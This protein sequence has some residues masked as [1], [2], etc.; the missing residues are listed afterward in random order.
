LDQCPPCQHAEE[1]LLEVNAFII[2]KNTERKEKM[3]LDLS[4]EIAWGM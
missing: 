3:H 2:G 1:L 4:G